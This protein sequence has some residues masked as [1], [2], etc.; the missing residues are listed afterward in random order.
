MKSLEKRLS[1]ALHTQT[2]VDAARV[3]QTVQAVRMHYAAK[4]PRP[5]IGF[6][7]F[8]VL[9]ARLSGVRMWL[10]QGLVM[11]ALLCGLNLVQTNA[12]ILFTLRLLP[13][14]LG[15]C[16]VATVTAAI[17]LVYRS[18]RYRMYEMEHACYFSGA[19]LLLAR[20]LFIG[21]GMLLTLAATVGVVIGHRWLG[22]GC[23]V[24]YVCVPCL[25]TACGDLALLRRAPLERFPVLGVVLGG[26]LVLAM[27]M[28]LH[29][30]W[31]PQQFGIGC[32]A[33]CIGLVLLCAVQV[34]HLAHTSSPAIR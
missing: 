23:A 9:Q 32:G 34:Y 5:R 22:I 2:A 11:L 24:L 29:F 13:F 25:V 21:A 17:P 31:Y 6:G 26:G 30:S 4:P 14:L 7:R 10:W 19:Q 18:V 20:L 8:I 15:C 1:A 28:M 33:L 27:R 12:N 3:E 16:G